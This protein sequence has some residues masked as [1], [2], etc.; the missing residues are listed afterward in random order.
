MTLSHVFRPERLA[1]LTATLLAALLM[2]APLHAQRRGAGEQS[3]DT[4]GAGG[5]PSLAALIAAAASDSDLRVAVLRFELDRAVFDRRYDVPLSPV[6]IERERIFLQGWD[7]RLDALDRGG[8]N[9]AGQADYDQLREEIR[10]GLAELEEQERRREAMAPLV[11]FARPIQI[12]QENRRDRLDV[13]PFA[14][15]QTVEDAR[16][17]V[18]RLTAALAEGGS[19]AFPG[20]TPTVASDALGHLDS[21][22]QVLE[23]WYRFYHSFDPLFTWWVQT[24]YGELNEALAGYREAIRRAWPD[25]G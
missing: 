1:L 22:G 4:T 14:A 10:A 19:S 11:P 3:T 25:A 9:E 5:A 12:L 20:L 18:L 15:A 16:K 24:P 8:L 7:R 17:E 6:R 21:L 13:D 2:A 23:G